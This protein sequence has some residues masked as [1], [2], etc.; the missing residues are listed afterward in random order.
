MKIPTMMIRKKLWMRWRPRPPR[1]EKLKEKICFEFWIGKKRLTVRFPSRAPET[2]YSSPAKD[3]SRSWRLAGAKK[4][5]GM[6][7]RPRAV[8]LPNYEF[9]KNSSTKTG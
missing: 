6:I 9:G 2:S 8:L 3:A 7:A 4:F 1:R 5:L